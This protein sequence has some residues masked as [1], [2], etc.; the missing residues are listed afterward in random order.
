MKRVVRRSSTSNG[1]ILGAPWTWQRKPS[2]AYSGA[3]T[4]PGLAAFR[5][6]STSAAVLPIEEMIPMPVTTTRLMLSVLLASVPAADVGEQADPEILGLINKPAVGLHKA[7]GDAKRDF[8]ANDALY[9]DAV[10]DEFHV[11]GDLAG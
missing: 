9:V 11:I 7:L 6:S 8:G 1:S 3:K 2:W 5:L 4:M 10:F